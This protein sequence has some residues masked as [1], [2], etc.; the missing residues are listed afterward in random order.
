ML[1]SNNLFL[2]C[3]IFK[4]LFF[5]HRK[6]LELWGKGLKTSKAIAEVAYYIILIDSFVNIPVFFFFIL[7]HVQP[8]WRQ[9]SGYEHWPIYLFSAD[10][11]I[12][13]EYKILL[14]DKEN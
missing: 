14:F 4:T 3:N 7:L 5:L 13:V 2:S 10:E 11:L 1:I 12:L 8:F 9:I 6:N